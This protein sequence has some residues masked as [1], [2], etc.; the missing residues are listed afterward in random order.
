MEKKRYEPIR[1]SGTFCYTRGFPTSDYGLSGEIDECVLSRNK[2]SLDYND[3]G[4]PCYIE[5]RSTDSF[6]FSG[7]YRMRT[8]NES[9]K[10]TLK[11]YK[12]NSHHLFYGEWSSG[13]D[14]GKYLF[15][16]EEEEFS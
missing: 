10:V 6:I 3:G 8:S 13:A 12:N 11:Y 5:A 7:E 9:G 14:I 1:L 4:E 16:L 2:L 15:E